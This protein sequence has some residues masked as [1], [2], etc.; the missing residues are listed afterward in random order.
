MGGRILLFINFV[1]FGIVLDY[2]DQGGKSLQSNCKIFMLPPFF[3]SFPLK[4]VRKAITAVNRYFVFYIFSLCFITFKRQ[5]KNNLFLRKKKGYI[6]FVKC[7][8]ANCF[9][10]GQKII[11][12]RI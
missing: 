7:L 12:K 11:L 6:Q 8:E 5:D 10:Y 2:G 3:I 1:K 9:V 4:E